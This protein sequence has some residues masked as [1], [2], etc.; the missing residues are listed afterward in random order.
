MIVHIPAVMKVNAP[1]LVIVQTPV[2]EELKL[3]VRPDVAVADKVGVV[4]RFWAPGLLN[5]IVWP[6]VA[7]VTVVVYVRVVV[8]SPAVTIVLIVFAPTLRAIAPEG[9]PEVTETPLTVTVAVPSFTM[10]VIDTDETAF[11]TEAA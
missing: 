5:V 10:G 6:A 2:V 9:V 11:A 4:P 3:T 7:R 8:P 1:P